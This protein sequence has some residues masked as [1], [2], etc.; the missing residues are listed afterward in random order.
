MFLGKV[1]WQIGFWTFIFVHFEILKKLS[2][3]KTRYFRFFKYLNY[4]PY[5]QSVTICIPAQSR[6]SL[7]EQLPRNYPLFLWATHPRLLWPQ[8][9]TSQTAPHIPALSA[10]FGDTVRRPGL[11]WPD[12]SAAI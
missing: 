4:L 5:K 1:F 6:V 10:Q 11:Q 9:A 7:L 3:E 8:T 12:S 2:H